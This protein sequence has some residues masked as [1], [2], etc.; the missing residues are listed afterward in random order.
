MNAPRRTSAHV[1]GLV[2]WDNGAIVTLRTKDGVIERDRR[3]DPTVLAFH[4]RWTG[5]HAVPRLELQRAEAPAAAGLHPQEL[6]LVPEVGPEVA[7]AAPGRIGG[8]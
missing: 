4:G 1:L 2:M 6:Q 3:G 5:E 8:W 7:R